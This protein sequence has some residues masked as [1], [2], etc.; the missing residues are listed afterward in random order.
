MAERD[1][2]CPSCG[3]N[4]VFLT[5]YMQKTSKTIFGCICKTCRHQW[6]EKKDGIIPREAIFYP[7]WQG[8]ND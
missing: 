3:S 7:D 8:D 5:Q 6:V 4:D 1:L 2:S